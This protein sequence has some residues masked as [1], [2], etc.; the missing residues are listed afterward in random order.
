MALKDEIA[1]ISGSG[2]I[3]FADKVCAY[4]G[5][6]RTPSPIRTFT[7]TNMLI[8]IDESVRGRNVF[9]FQSGYH[10]AIDSSRLLAEHLGLM[11]AVLDADAR[12]VRCAA[13]PY[14]HNVRSD[15]KDEPRM[16]VMVKASLNALLGCG[17]THFLAMHLHD[18]HIKEYPHAPFPELYVQ[19]LVVGILERD[20]HISE[21][22][23]SFKIVSPDTGAKKVDKEISEILRIKTVLLDKEREAHD[24]KAECNSII[25]DITGKTGIA[26]DDEVMSGGT[27]KETAK[28]CRNAGAQRM[29]TWVT[30]PIF[31]GESY[32]I[33]QQ[34]FDRI[35]ITNTIPVD[36]GRI[37]PD[38]L[39]VIDVSPIFGE[40]IKAIHYGRGLSV[41][42]VCENPF[43][44]LA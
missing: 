2:S 30:H 21:N 38:K 28:I 37:N 3:K 32:E 43:G 8:K 12:P 27:L 33:L 41:S 15:K 16:G 36:Q 19:Y 24:E 9:V 35:Y 14:C 22:P 11:Q 20:W 4:L 6:E 18:T 26:V 34:C 10:P 44:L 5:I 25:G 23:N 13:M 40:A 39:T 1:I 17:A 7:N 29:I 42:A 31:T